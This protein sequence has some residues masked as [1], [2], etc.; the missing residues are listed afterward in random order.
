[1]SFENP[2]VFTK[3]ARDRNRF[4]RGKGEVIKYPPV[5]HLL[6]IL[7]SAWCSM[8]LRQCLT[9]GRMLIFTQPQ[10]IIGADFAGQAKP[11]RAHS[12]PFAGHALSFIVVI[13]NAK[14]FLKVFP[15]V[16]QIVLRLGRDHTRTL[17]GLCAVIVCLTH[18]CSPGL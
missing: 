13:A 16:F 7:Q 10:K 11:F 4:R 9:C 15:R 3:Q 1:M 2:F 18:H 5:G 8:P 14:V 17:H 6:A 12:N